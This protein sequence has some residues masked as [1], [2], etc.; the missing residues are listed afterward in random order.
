M[1]NCI[2]S[3][4]RMSRMNESKWCIRKMDLVTN[5]ERVERERERARSF[6]LHHLTARIRKGWRKG[7]LGLR[8]HSFVYSYSRNCRG[9][10][11]I[12][13]TTVFDVSW[14][15]ERKNKFIDWFFTKY[16][17]IIPF[18]SL[19]YRFFLFAA[20]ISAFNASRMVI[21]RMKAKYRT[22]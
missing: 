13:A 1:V 19:L 5:A 21:E 18:L 12:F 6:L 8:Y 10:V 9:Y 20:A 14:A 17:C 22:Q 16:W 7:V 2:L 4:G 15:F 3:K 11:I